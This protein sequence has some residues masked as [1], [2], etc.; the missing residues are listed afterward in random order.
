[1]KVA[2]A[3]GGVKSV[4]AIELA[5]TQNGEH[6]LLWSASG[7]EE[8]IEKAASQPPQLLLVDVT[9]DDPGCVEITRRV[10]ALGRC[11]VLLVVDKPQTRMDVIYEAMG[12]GALDVVVCP[13]LRDKNQLSGDDVLR[14]K[15]QTVARILGVSPRAAS[16]KLVPRK[17]RGPKLVAIG[18]STG[19]PNA[20]AQI[21]AALPRDFDAALLIV[22]HV[23][24]EF[25]KGLASWLQQG[26]SLRVELAASG[27]FPQP[28][29]A[30]IAGTN[31]HMIM[32]QDRSLGYTSEPR[33]VPYRPSVDALFGSLAE[34]WPVPAVA[35]LLTG[36]GRDGAK[37]MKRLHDAGWHTIAQDQ[38]SSVV[39]G[40]P[41]AAI[42][43][44]AATRVLSLSEIAAAIVEA[45][46]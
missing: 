9:I 32:C 10:M 46:G 38:A 39:F 29:V 16:N 34:H 31:D 5:L 15:V 42:E 35:V 17:G 26:T 8:A 21:L 25:S 22:Q 36:M 13:K 30:L 4:R 11:A 7:G 40:M 27:V 14:G 20:L 18:A 23:D 28:G 37:G 45:C 2:I 24:S 19:G 44:G 6:Q 3:H 33:N 1:V 41:K 12:L 43:Q